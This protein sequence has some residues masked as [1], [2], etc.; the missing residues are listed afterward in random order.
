VEKDAVSKTLAKLITD[1]AFLVTAAQNKR[2]AAITR[3]VASEALQ[4]RW[5]VPIDGALIRFHCPSGP[6]VAGAHA[7][8]RSEPETRDWI[9]R[10]VGEGEVLWDIGANIGLFALYA[11]LAKKARVYAFEPNA[12]TFAVLVR[13]VALNGVGALVKPLPVALSGEAG[14]DSYFLFRPEIG[15]AMGAVGAPVN[16]E[17]PFMPAG[18]ETCLKLRADDVAA[19]PGMEPPCHIKLD[20]DG[21]E[22]QVLAGARRILERVRTVCVELLP[23]QAA[24]NDAVG[25]IL[26]E[27]DLIPESAPAAVGTRN[28]IFVRR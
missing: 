20:V 16:V 28:T 12:R 24:Q 7:L 26:M 19:L 22:T 4:Q 1:F 17:G 18:V 11:A 15:H 9:R 13:N 10:H 5:D 6:T 2:R 25:R 8:T 23:G 14:L 3:A 21:H 27:A